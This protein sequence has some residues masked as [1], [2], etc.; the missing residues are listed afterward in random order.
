[1]SIADGLSEVV[2]WVD[3]YWTDIRG[4]SLSYHHAA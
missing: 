2:D 1:M 3:A 4:S